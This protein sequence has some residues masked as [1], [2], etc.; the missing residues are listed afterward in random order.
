[1][2]S[3][4]AISTI[5]ILVLT[6]A[7]IITCVV[8]FL[9]VRK[10]VR[11]FSR[12]VFGTSDI[13]EAA[14][15]MKEEMAVTPKSVSGMTNLLLPKVVQDFPDFQYDE[16]KEKSNNVITSYLQAVTN[17]NPGLLTEGNSELTQQLENHIL[18]N[19]NRGQRE[20]F[21][22]VRI[23]RTE[24][25]RYQKTAGRCIITFQSSLE[26]FHYLT[27]ENSLTPIKGSN[28]LKYQTR[29]NVDL[30]YIQDRDLVENTM[31]QGLA[32]NCPNCGGPLPK[33]GAKFC[34]YCGS[35]VVEFN[36]RT[37]SFSNLEE[38]Q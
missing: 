1:M 24:L 21:D 23:H 29:F 26:C 35:P 30:I 13:T 20:H 27:K 14:T 9:K 32:M 8:I 36:I 34:E 31:D 10:K 16:M 4:F 2:M 6:L 17:A 38:I 7:I 5:I 37:W 28:S 33:L 11:H 19:A 12:Q 25:H 22:S 3:F 15:N 18:M